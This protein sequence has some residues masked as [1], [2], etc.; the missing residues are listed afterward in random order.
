MLLLKRPRE[1]KSRRREE[2]SIDVI[3]EDITEEEEDTEEDMVAD[4]REDML[5]S[6]ED[7]ELIERSI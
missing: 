3:E 2:E 1:P 4:G 5:V 7:G 6:S